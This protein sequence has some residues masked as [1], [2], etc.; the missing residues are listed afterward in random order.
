MA[1]TDDPVQDS[2]QA[3]SG[4]VTTFQRMGCGQPTSKNLQP[5]ME[6]THRSL[7]LIA[8]L[9]LFAPAVSAWD[10]GATAI[11]ASLTGVALTGAGLVLLGLCSAARGEARFR[12]LNL[13]L[14]GVGL[15]AIFGYEAA[16]MTLARTYITDEGA[17]VHAAAVRLTH[18]HDPFTG[19]YASSLRRYAVAAPTYLMN[20]RAVQTLGYP[21]LPVL[22]AAP[23]IALDPNTLAVSLVNTVALCVA[24]ALL[25]S[26]LPPPIK[27][28][29]V[30]ICADILTLPF[31]AYIG[32]SG[33]MMLPALTLVAYRWRDIGL[34]GRL[35]QN[36]VARAVAL[37][38]A[39]ATN[40]LAWF[41]SPFLIVGIFLMRRQS[42]GRR[43][44]ARLVSEFTS[45][46]LLTFLSIN[47]V[48]IVWNP[49]SWVSG[50]LG[51]LLQHAVPFGQGLINLSQFARIGG[52]RLDYYSYAAMLLYL[53]LLV[54][55]AI[56]F[57]R[58]SACCFLLPLLSLY[59]SERP[60]SSYWLLLV[61]VTLVSVLSAGTEPANVTVQTSPRGM[62]GTGVLVPL[63]LLAPAAACLV[64]ALTSSAPLRIRVLARQL[65]RSGLVTRVMVSVRNSSGVAIMPHFA[66]DSTSLISGFWHAVEGPTVLLPHERARYL[67]A[68]PS[69]SQELS[70]NSSFVVQAVTDTPRTISSSPSVSPA[71]IQ[72]A[73]AR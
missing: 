54:L 10:A 44:S 30:I 45:I 46:S 61:G 33:V 36:G 43:Q 39:A 31:F 12:Q 17:L 15:L 32:L 71:T 73:V 16:Q 2:K 68:P 11:G 48:F 69:G 8:A 40:Q 55:Y 26:S 47:I 27:P 14:L 37:G 66:I 6:A 59:V 53:A 18:G 64:F 23:V 41:I 57:N 58:L 67:L 49:G 65:N 24:M 19:S 63:G 22:L 13:A 60:L 28:L 35:A 21:A 72:L 29:A 3:R 51:P 7:A 42:H 4:R 38:L 1:G 34:S 50:V 20:G 25:F 5:P 62:S 70:A 9:G 52:G 56:H